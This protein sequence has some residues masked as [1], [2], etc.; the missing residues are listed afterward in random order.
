[1][2]NEPTPSVTDPATVER[3]AEYWRRNVR[4]VGALVAIWF[5]SLI[6]I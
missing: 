5:L 2:Q 4:Y 1:M 6:H 3:H